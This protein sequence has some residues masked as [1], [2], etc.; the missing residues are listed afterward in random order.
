M[1]SSPAAGRTPDR[2]TA[3][4]L[5]RL[6]GD[7][8]RNAWRGLP[9]P[10][11]AVTPDL[12][13]TAAKPASCTAPRGQSGP[14]PTSVE[15]AFGRCPRWHVRAAGTPPLGVVGPMPAPHP[16]RRSSRPRSRRR[17]WQNRPD[18]RT[19]T[20]RSGTTVGV[21]GD[22]AAGTEMLVPAAVTRPTWNSPTPV[23][24]G[25]GRSCLFVALSGRS[26]GLHARHG[27][28]VEPLDRRCSSVRLRCLG[29]DEKLDRAL[30][31]RV[32]VRPQCRRTMLSRCCLR[33]PGDRQMRQ[34]HVTSECLLTW[35]NGSRGSVRK[36]AD[37]SYTQAVVGSIPIAPTL[38]TGW[39]R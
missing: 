13:P 27:Q 6:V 12:P 21:A 18:S 26:D 10:R 9:A 3:T 22:R 32:L 37:R 8:T 20:L 38:L 16:R 36:R 23:H 17:S 31:C 30:Q 15:G 14:G 33:I 25:Q 1:H 28:V 19:S 24:Q 35:E 5:T 4:R 29:R 11:P 34:H 39:E 7:R 2:Q